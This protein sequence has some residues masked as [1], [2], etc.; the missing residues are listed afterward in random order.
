MQT[1]QNEGLA[2]RSLTNLVN[3]SNKGDGNPSHPEVL[4]EIE[5][6]HIRVR[7]NGLG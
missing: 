6:A 5:A 7:D 1:P 2:G 3:F 4:A